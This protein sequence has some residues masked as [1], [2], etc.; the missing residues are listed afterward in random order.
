MTTSTGLRVAL[1]AAALAALIV[2]LNVFSAG[3]RIVC[4][5]VIVVVTVLAARDRVARDSPWWR[6]LVAGA[7][8]S[9]VGAI[10]AQPAVTLGGGWR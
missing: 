3:L 6:L 1:A 5:G 8:A 4:L 7:A 2:L 9:V 10:V